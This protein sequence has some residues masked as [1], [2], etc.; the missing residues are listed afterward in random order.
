M[1]GELVVYATDPPHGQ[2][3][4]FPEGRIEVE[5][6]PNIIAVCEEPAEQAGG[7]GEHAEDVDY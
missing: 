2:D 1:M 3:G 6:V 5:I 4:Q 7:M